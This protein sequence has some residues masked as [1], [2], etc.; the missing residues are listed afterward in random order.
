MTTS[1]PLSVDVTC[2]AGGVRLAF[3][4]EESLTFKETVLKETHRRLSLPQ[5]GREGIVWVIVPTNHWVGVPA[6][7]LS[8]SWKNL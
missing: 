3:S 2:A 6:L 8:Q 1:I 4:I 5:Q 7:R